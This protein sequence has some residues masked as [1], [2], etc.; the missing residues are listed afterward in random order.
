M[1][2]ASVLVRLAITSFQS[3]LIGLI[4]HW[5][6]QEEGKKRIPLKSLV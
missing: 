6:F 5:R 3:G 4:G 2:G 1:S